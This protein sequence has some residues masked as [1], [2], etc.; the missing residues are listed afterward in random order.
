MPIRKELS[1]LELGFRINNSW[2]QFY[3][4]HSIF[5][6]PARSMMINMVA[7]N[8]Y[9]G[10]IKCKQQ[11]ESINFNHGYHM[12]FKFDAARIDEL[13]RTRDNYKDDLRL[14][15]HGV[16]GD[17]IFNSLT[18]FNPVVSTNIDVM[19][20]IFLG[21]IKNMFSYW[22][23]HPAT[24]KYSLRSMLDNLNEKLLSCRPPQY[25]QQCPRK[26]DD[27]QRWRAHEFMNFILFFA[28]PV[29][30]ESMPDAYFQHLLLLIISL[31]NLLSKKIQVSNLNKIQTYLCK[32]VSELESLYDEHIMTSSAHELLHLVK[33][34]RDFGPLNH[35]NCYQFEELNRKIT[36]LIK[37]QDLVGDEFIKLWNVS[38]SLSLYINENFLDEDCSQNKFT[39]FIKRNFS[40]KSSNLKK[41]YS[42]KDV[43]KLGKITT[44]FKLSERAYYFI[45]EIVNDKDNLIYYER[46]YYN[47]ILYACE[48]DFLTKFCNSVIKH[49]NKIGVICNIL[50]S[51]DSILL[52]CKELTFIKNPFFNNDC[53]EI[54]SFFA[55]YS[56][57]S[58]YFYVKQNEIKNLKKLFM[59]NYNEQIVLV[60]LFT[61]CHLF[62]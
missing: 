16:K 57:S 34:T 58:N 22:F 35:V 37:S 23:D 7:S 42:N 54:K 41:K 46:L 52:V 5:D 11:G 38:K 50:K 17:C 6:K 33:C 25:V 48:L 31:E 62:S 51:D 3:V 19:H 27:F 36:R 18:Y 55:L 53:N 10:C 49:N 47:N 24:K 8:G 28:I 61:S 12:V 2:Y 26:L 21:L 13:I 1:D 15:R 59:T 39:E 29:F 60:S 56:I 9:Y 40:I 45:K 30:Y 20:S 4:L 32:F 43:L 14:T 44:Q